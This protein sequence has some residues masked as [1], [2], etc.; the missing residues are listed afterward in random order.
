MTPVVAAT[1]AKRRRP[2]AEMRGYAEHLVALLAP[3]CARLEVAGSIRRRRPDPAD[4]EVVAIARCEP[5]GFDLFENPV[6][7]VDVLDARCH[8]LR[9]AGVFADR[10]GKDGKAAFG[11]RFKR[12]VWTP[13]G[14]PDS[15]AVDL[16]VTVAEAW[17]L[18]LVLRTGP[19]D[20]NHRLVTPERQRGWLPDGLR[21]D[22]G[23]LWRDGR[24]VPTP[25]ED[26]LFRAVGLPYLPPEARTDA[27]RPVWRPG[28]TRVWS[29]PEPAPPVAPPVP[30]VPLAL[31]VPLAPAPGGAADSPA[32]YGRCA[33]CGTAL[34][35]VPFQTMPVGGRNQ[36]VC[37]PCF[38][39]YFARAPRDE[40][41]LL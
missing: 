12:V 14:A 10:L 30:G 13:P 31:G 11:P 17:G 36:P 38:R 24:R 37:R 28:G 9:A 7:E 15:V 25:E 35:R 18:Q 5:A 33:A 29:V 4:V 20:F 22:G 39:A 27:V 34:P 21:V 19:G 40:A 6:G 23:A 1:A 41:G 32:P 26:D 2:L 3:G 8:A 16:F